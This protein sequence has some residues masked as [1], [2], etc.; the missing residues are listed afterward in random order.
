[1]TVSNI[2][3]LSGGLLLIVYSCFLYFY[4]PSFRNFWY[5]IHTRMTESN[6]QLWSVGQK[7]FSYLIFTMGVGL[8]V[9]AATK[10]VSQNHT[11]ELILIALVLWKFLK[12]VV[13]RGLE[14]RSPTS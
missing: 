11:F 7:I 3:I 4:P 10:I 14:K 9:C 8:T 12:F 1:M 2:L 13:N 5:G 6:S